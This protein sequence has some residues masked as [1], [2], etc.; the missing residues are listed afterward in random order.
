MKKIVI[1]L[2][3]IFMAINLL[4]QAPAQI[5]YQGIA[6][7]SSGTPLGDQ[8]IKLRLSIRSGSANGIIVYQETRALKTNSFG[9]FTIAIGSN[10]ASNIVGSM[11]NINWGID[12]GK[13]L[14][15]ELDAGGGNN[16]TDMGSTQLLSVPYALHAAS[17]PPG[18]TAGGDLSGSF[19]NPTIAANA[20]TGEKIADGSITTTKLADGVVT[21]I[22]LADGSVLTTKLADGSVLTAKLADG[23]VST[24][25]LADGSVVTAKIADATI[26]KPKL[27]AGVLPTTLPPS[28]TAGGDLSG[29]Y[30]FPLVA[31]LRGI[32]IST[33]IPASGQIL[34]YDGNQ[35]AFAADNAGG[36]G[37]SFTLPF[38]GTG[39][40][41]ANIFSITSTGASHAIEGINSTSS[42]D[43][44]GV[45]GH[46]SSASA[47]ANSAGVRGINNSAGTE[48]FGIWGTHNGFG[49]GVY[50]SSNTG[51]GI[52]GF[53]AAGYGVF[54]QADGETG[55]G[56]FATS[57]NG[58]PAYVDISNSNS[59]FDAL[60][61]NNNGFG[62]GITTIATYG[63]G[64]LG[65]ANDAGGAAV[66]GVN[67][68]SGEAVVGRTFSNNA[69]GVVGRNDGSYAGVKGY[70]ASEGGIGVIAQANVDGAGNGTALV[71][72]LQAGEGNTAVFKVNGA[73]VA[74]ID[75][76]GKGY[77]N[78]GTVAGGADVAE[79][80]DVTGSLSSYEPGDVL[81]I[82]ADADRKVEKSTAPYSTLVAGVYATKP[83]LMLTEEN[84]TENKLD[85][86]VPMGVIGVIPT[87]VCL[88]GGAIKRG[89][90][91][92][93]SSIPGVAM[94]A[95]P[96]KVKVGQ[97]IGKALQN[98]DGQGTGKINV[99]V[100]V[101]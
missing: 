87:K 94:K 53:S 68:A 63:N 24:A 95:D 93:T 74:R 32:A 2:S 25:K 22:K 64:L 51:T 28:G 12:G 70:N 14:Q 49:P 30:P 50:G 1:L 40:A 75:H 77:F 18:G 48:G 83:G 60:F 44:F 54:A 80:F 66:L 85:K 72:E 52:K 90:L 41:T 59:F 58:I 29:N 56:L 98:Y 55:I 46:V 23:A 69:A 27:A 35:W 5:N 11:D 62:S 4:G 16:F 81:I 8:N 86:M 71:A 89:D 38:A 96:E 20:V 79:Y 99:L 88:E 47:G 57:N 36:G 37:S 78:G 97:V 82:S 7:N 45:L 43:G 92:V 65:I 42:V 67:N 84:A 10:G 91:L 19:P 76:T 13:F 3:S 39:N 9:M 73:N 26:T 34:K 31:R 33:A 15:V 17:A 61:V 101:K 100:S 6:R 21:T